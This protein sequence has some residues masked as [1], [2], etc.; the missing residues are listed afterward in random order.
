M[1]KAAPGDDELLVGLSRTSTIFQFPTDAMLEGEMA[2]ATRRVV[3]RGAIVFDVW[4]SSCHFHVGFEDDSESTHAARIYAADVS[5]IMYQAGVSRGEAVRALAWHPDDVV[6]ACEESKAPEGAI[7]WLFSEAENEAP[8]DSCAAPAIVHVTADRASL[9]DKMAAPS[10][11]GMHTTAD[12]R[13]I[14][15]ATDDGGPPQT[16]AIPPISEQEESA[17]WGSLLPQLSIP[18]GD[19]RLRESTNE[20]LDDYFRERD[21]PVATCANDAADLAAIAATQKENADPCLRCGETGHRLRDCPLYP[22]VSRITPFERACAAA[23]ALVYPVRR[24]CAI[25]MYEAPDP[26]SAPPESSSSTAERDD[27]TGLFVPDIDLVAAQAGVSRSEA[28]RALV[29]NGGDIVNAIFSLV[30]I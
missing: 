29:S 15:H 19:P 11:S 2:R 3:E 16:D 25:E 26:I 4:G 13:A 30:G 20:M 24:P 22:A 23:M 8:R 27:E 12:P 18:I 17:L 14:S 9:G 7:S 28:V 10:C 1:E 21:A 5:Y 6:D